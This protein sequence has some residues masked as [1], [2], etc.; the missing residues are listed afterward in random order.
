MSKVKEIE[1][2]IKL[3]KFWAMVDIALGLFAL[4]VS[5]YGLG[6]VQAIPAYLP[7]AADVK[8]LLS[9]AFIDFILVGAFLVISGAMTWYESSKVRALLNELQKG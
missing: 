8:G 1:G 3:L 9:S 2:R 6:S 7:L 4:I 5:A